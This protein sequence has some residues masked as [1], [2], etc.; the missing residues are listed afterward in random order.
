MNRKTI[1]QNRTRASYLTTKPVASSATEA[2][3]VAGLTA[4]AQSGAAGGP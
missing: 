4:A 2:T 1:A 3:A